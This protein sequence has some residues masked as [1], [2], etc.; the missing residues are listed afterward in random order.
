M[1]GLI[2]SW[3]NFGIYARDGTLFH[4]MKYSNFDFFLVNELRF[5]SMIGRNQ[6]INQ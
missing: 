3:K 4:K 5:V 6:K 1:D 2:K